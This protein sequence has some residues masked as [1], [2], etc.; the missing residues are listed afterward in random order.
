MPIDNKEKRL[1]EVRYSVNRFLSLHDSFYKT[2]GIEI[3]YSESIVNDIVDTY[4]ILLDNSIKPYIPE[5]SKAQTFKVASGLEWATIYKMPLKTGNP[6]NDIDINV[7]L[8]Y[9]I[10]FDI[11][12]Q[13]KGI[14]LDNAKIYEDEDLQKL[15]RNH[16]SFIK[17]AAADDIYSFS[18]FGNS[19][20]W[21][22]FHLI[23]KKILQEN[24]S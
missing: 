22:A 7:S 15:S 16:T 10:A 5:T 11:L 20:Y 12:L 8:S 24:N 14:E 3:Q 13:E 1:R 19:L 6:D 9:F 21:E 4:E 23:C 18:V 17:Y 2:Q